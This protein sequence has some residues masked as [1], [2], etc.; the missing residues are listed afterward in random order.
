MNGGIG[1]GIVIMEV[2]MMKG[3]VDD[4]SSYAYPYLA[5]ASTTPV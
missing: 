5:V 4:N 1:K 2:T 3:V